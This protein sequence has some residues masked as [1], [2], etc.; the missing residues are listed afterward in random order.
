MYNAYSSRVNAPATSDT[1]IQKVISGMAVKMRTD[2]KPG[3]NYIAAI[4]EFIATGT[5]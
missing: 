1:T 5:N 2:N 4:N 3:C